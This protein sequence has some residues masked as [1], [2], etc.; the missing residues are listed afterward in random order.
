MVSM[1]TWTPVDDP[2]NCDS[3]WIPAPVTCHLTPGNAGNTTRSSGDTTVPVGNI[4]W[5]RVAV[6]DRQSSTPYSRDAATF[7]AS[8][9]G[10]HPHPS[11][12]SDVSVHVSF[13]FRSTPDR[14]R[15]MTVTATGAANGDNT[16]QTVHSPTP[17]GA[18][19]N[20]REAAPIA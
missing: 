15:R 18:H 9:P 13:P 17:T 10:H 6:L 19:G 11:T 20:A 1:D 4:T 12:T 8:E 3:Q 2:V 14:D 16:C 7:L 5:A